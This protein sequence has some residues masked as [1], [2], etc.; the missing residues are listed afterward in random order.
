[1]TDPGHSRFL[2]EQ[3]CAALA[4]RV[5]T[6]RHGGG[7]SVTRIA[8]T[9]HGAVRFTRN[10]IRS[11]G[12]RRNA[13]IYVTR[14]IEGASRMTTGNQIDDESL[15]AM[16]LRAERLIQFEYETGDI[17]FQQHANARP[18]TAVDG[19][20]DAQLHGRRT[21]DS[22]KSD[23]PRA[24]E[25]AD[26]LT[27]M[28]PRAA[29][30]FASTQIPP[31]P[32][33]HPTLFFES[34]FAMA[35]PKRA[36]AVAPLVAEATRAGM[37][38]SGYIDVSAT[39]TAVM[40][41]YGNS[42]YYPMTEAQYTVTVRDP[43]GTG[44]GWAGV[45]GNDWNRID[46]AR[47]S[48]IALDKCLRSRNPVRV[49]PGRYTTIL[50]P[51]AVHDLF[52]PIVRFLPFTVG[53]K[54][55]DERLTVTA[56]PMDPDCGFLPIDLDGNAYH[57]ATWIDRGIVT[58]LPY[59]RLYAIR[60]LHKNTGL[61][62]SFAYRLQSASGNT[63]ASMEQMIAETERGIVVTRFW[64]PKRLASQDLMLTGYTRDGTWLVEHG[65][66]TKPVKNLKFT[67]N[68][69]GTFSNVMQIG[70]AQRVFSRAWPGC[71]AAVVPPM[72]VR[73]FN[74]TALTDAV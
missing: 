63:P 30:L 56:D 68:L 47:L 49:E 35:S 19:K 50:E 17:R 16:V 23:E 29:Q 65:K 46:G 52:W 3:E 42:L 2:S 66:I 44:S 5:A 25:A 72:K 45:D 6:F 71:P 4:A 40:D 61:P 9:W 67:A 34:T 32:I 26:S 39:G 10:Q 55:I 43:D 37:L 21:G 27:G 11:S 14:N 41:T 58:N 60:T 57:A 13:D 28:D 51:Q 18:A 59:G 54:V 53:G 36:A 74:F 62:N 33:E 24:R 48:A 7:E 22:N 8:S 15:R 12:D 20:L 38:A 69:T 1:M 70:V 31:E 64:F 73:D